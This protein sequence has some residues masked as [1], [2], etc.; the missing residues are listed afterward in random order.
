MDIISLL[1][2][3]QVDA[4]QLVMKSSVR[5]IFLMVTPLL[6]GNSAKGIKAGVWKYLWSTLLLVSS[7]QACNTSA[8]GSSAAG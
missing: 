6:N 3:S 5:Q 7:W 2:M 8:L 1:V 4:F